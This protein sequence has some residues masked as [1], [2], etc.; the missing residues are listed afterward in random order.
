MNSEQV[1][2]YSTYETFHVA[3]FL[4]N[5]RAQH[6]QAMALARMAVER[7]T[8][9]DDLNAL[10]PALIWL[11]D[12][13]VILVKRTYLRMD[14]REDQI[15]TSYNSEIQRDCDMLAYELLFAALERV[16]WREI[17]EEWLA[18]AQEG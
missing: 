2:G 8:Q 10:S 15:A 18:A 9:M 11:M 4:S 16:N 3:M 7:G 13:L 12:E 14:F 5:N 17:A 6:D 1:S